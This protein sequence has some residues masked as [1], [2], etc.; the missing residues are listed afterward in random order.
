[1]DSGSQSETYL[2]TLNYLMKYTVKG[3]TIYPT[4]HIT[5]ASEH[6]SIHQNQA[7]RDD[8]PK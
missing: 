4:D 7:P 5:L 3:I 1:M 6:N 2:K 8:E